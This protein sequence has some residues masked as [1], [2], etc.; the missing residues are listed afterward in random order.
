MVIHGNVWEMEFLVV[1][2]PSLYNGILG[3]PALN[4]L[5]ATVSTYSLTLEVYTLIGLFASYGE[6]LM[7]WECFIASKA[8]A[9]HFIVAEKLK[10]D[11]DRNRKLQPQE[12]FELYGVDE[13]HVDRHIRIEKI[14]L[15]NI[16]TEIGKLLLEFQDVFS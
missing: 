16:H 1:D 3:R 2:A 14:L 4:E 11:E 15:D 7:G 13:R 10:D 5:K 9:E 12:E 6:L 8:K